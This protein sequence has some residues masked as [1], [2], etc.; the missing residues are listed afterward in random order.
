MIERAPILDREKYDQNATDKD[1]EKTGHFDPRYMAA[2]SLVWTIIKG[3][4]GTNNK[5]IVKGICIGLTL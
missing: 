4:I 2:R 1:L 5:L 3:C